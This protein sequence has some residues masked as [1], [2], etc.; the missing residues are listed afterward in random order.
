MKTTLTTAFLCIAVFA[1]FNARGSD[2]SPATAGPDTL[3]F[4]HQKHIKDAGAACTDCHKDV[5]DNTG[6]AAAIHPTMTSCGACHQDDLDKKNC[7]LCHTNSIKAKPFSRT[8]ALATFS[9]KVHLDRGAQCAACHKGFET[10]TGAPAKKNMPGMAECQTCH[11]GKKANY[12]CSLCHADLST[13]KPNSHKSVRFLKEDHGRDARF[14]AVE[15]ENCHQQTWCDQC[16]Q[17]QLSIRIHSPNYLALHGRE[18]KRRDKNC[19]LCH[20]VQ[21]QCVTCHT[22]RK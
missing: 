10:L 12:E 1:A 11:N 8:R 16:H 7:A 2:G 18:A 17:G 19:A 13:I 22:G 6:G 21:N 9:H 20:E 3:K 15:C 5:A 14:S 4:S